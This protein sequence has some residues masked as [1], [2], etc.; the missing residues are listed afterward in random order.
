VT[1]LLRS[2]ISGIDPLLALQQVQPMND[3]ISN[4]EAPRRFNT[5]LIT[6]FAI[7]ALLLAVTGI[8]AIV[9]FSVSL[10][11]QEIAIRMALGAQRTSIARLVLIAG[12]K[13]ALIGC[14]LG[15]LGA[16]AISRLVSAFLFDVSATDPAVYFAAILTMMFMALLASALPATRAASADPIE[17]LRSM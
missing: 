15:V 1:Q 7:G 3:V 4:V 5:D 16:V 9:A 10:R 8:Y 12:A 6:A 14:G 2:T 13:M 17:A 11:T